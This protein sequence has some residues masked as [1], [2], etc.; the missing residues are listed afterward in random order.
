MLR[1]IFIADVRQNVML[2]QSFEA[3]AA[4]FSFQRFLSMT[5]PKYVSICDSHSWISRPE[6]LMV[7]SDYPQA[8]KTTFSKFLNTATATK[9][10]EPTDFRHSGAS[11]SLAGET[12]SKYLLTA[13]QKIADI[14]KGNPKSLTNDRLKERIV[15][16]STDLFLIGNSIGNR[17]T[18]EIFEKSVLSFCT[19]VSSLQTNFPDL[20]IE[21]VCVNVTELPSSLIVDDINANASLSLQVLLKKALGAS[22]EFTILRNSSMYFEEELR[23]LVSAY[24][25]T[26]STKLEFPPVDGMQ[27]SIQFDLSA[28]TFNA[29]DS[30]CPEDWVTST[31]FSIAS[32]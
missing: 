23:R 13:I 20:S 31:M 4:M 27:C 19:A 25:P 14:L 24:I 12:W 29:A 9:Q 15:I 2:D 6:C 7:L 16:Y 28:I 11:I 5:I 18:S 10:L 8:P 3:E 21:I 17:H 26:V 22:V 32:R 30:I 1:T